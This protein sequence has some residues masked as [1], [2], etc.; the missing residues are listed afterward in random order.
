[1][2][3]FMGYHNIR[4]EMKQF[5]NM[6][7]YLYPWSQNL[8]ESPFRELTNL[9]VDNIMEFV[10]RA[11]LGKPSYGS[12]L[13]SKFHQVLEDSSLCAMFSTRF[14]GLLFCVPGAHLNRGCMQRKCCA[15]PPMQ[16][17]SYVLV[18]IWK[19]KCLVLIAPYTPHIG[20]KALLQVAL[21]GRPPMDYATAIIKTNC[22]STWV[23][24]QPTSTFW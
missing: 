16:S 21:V 3:S 1:M 15:R 11:V 20:K 2:Q 13:P 23:I 18:C 17:G 8:I 4:E 12:T 22:A 7:V 19:M 6:L 24:I 9:Q 5:C 14:V 10:L